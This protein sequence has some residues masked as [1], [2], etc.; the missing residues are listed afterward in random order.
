ML[1]ALKVMVDWYEPERPNFRDARAF[2]AVL[3]IVERGHEFAKRVGEHQTKQRE[4]SSFSARAKTF[5]I[6]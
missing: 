3:S 6:G 4:A 5:S 1:S 2:D